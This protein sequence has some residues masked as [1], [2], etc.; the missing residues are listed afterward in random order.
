MECHPNPASS[1]I[2]L[3]ISEEVV[4]SYEYKITDLNGI[5]LSE[6]I[7]SSNDMIQI[8]VSEINPGIYLLQVFDAAGVSI[9]LEK[10]MITK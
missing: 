7:I 10:L 8:D 4:S 3:E 2:Q 5:G 1:L 6:G 9:H